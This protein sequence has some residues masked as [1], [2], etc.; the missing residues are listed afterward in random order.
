MDWVAAKLAKAA[1]SVVEKSLAIRPGEQVALVADDGSDMAIVQ[2]LLGAIHAV[3]AEPTLVMMPKRATAGARATRIAA[4]ALLGADVIIAPTSTGLGFT[5]EF[6][7]ALKENGARAI[8]MTGV[9]RAVLTGGAGLADYDEVFRITKPLADK[10]NAGLEVHL[11]CKNGSDFR[12]SIEGMPAGCGASFARE[13][14]EVSSFPSGESWQCPKPGT[15]NGILYADGSA[16]MLGVLEEPLGVV[17]KDGRAVDFKGGRQAEQLREIIRPIENGDNIGELS[18]GT[19]P[20]ARFLG[21]ITEDKK[22][23]GTVHF[24]L[25]NSVV[26]GPVKAEIHLDLLIMKPTLSVDGT[27][28]FQDGEI[29]YTG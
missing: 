26:G 6:G 25:G 5:S 8:V 14:G 21:N 3:D 2:A 18:I 16:H 7:Q 22:Q 9:D 15:A 27:T 28:L 24:A 19:N 4:S 1:K 23:I 17:F 20:M 29:V 10:M 13:A 12:A 11:T